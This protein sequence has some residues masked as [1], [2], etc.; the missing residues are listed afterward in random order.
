MGIYFV[1]SPFIGLSYRYKG[2]EA[3]AK[4]QSRDEFARP[5]PRT[6]QQSAIASFF[7]VSRVFSLQKWYNIRQ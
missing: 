2:N 6:D 5:T 4:W 3:S 7:S 1:L